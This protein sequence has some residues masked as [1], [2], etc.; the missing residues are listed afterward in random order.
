M[1]RALLVRHALCDPVGQRIAGR[2]DGI[3]LNARGVE[4]ARALASRLS[5]ETV[6]AVYTSPLERARE[7]AAAIAQVHQLAPIPSEAFT[8]LQFG[9][10]TGR[11]LAELQQDSR[12][13][14]FNA[15]RSV[16]RAPDGELMLDVQARAITELLRLRERHAGETV[17]VVSH[18]DVIRAVLCYLLGMPLDHL[19]RLRID[20]ASVNEIVFHGDVPELSA[21]N[22]VS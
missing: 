13:H 19:L 15:L 1:C 20:P 12:W 2:L 16:T 5:R 10:W 18:G 4:Q 7:T 3:A 9:A 11:T 8:E 6:A 22:V 17:V 14:A 21:L